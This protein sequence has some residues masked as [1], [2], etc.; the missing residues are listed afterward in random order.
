MRQHTGR[1]PASFLGV[2]GLRRVPGGSGADFQPTPTANHTPASRLVWLFVQVACLRDSVF[3]L[4]TRTTMQAKHTCT[5]AHT[6]TW[7]HTHTPLF[8]VT[9]FSS[10]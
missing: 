4:H 5:H 3:P 10:L 1:P 6:N 9:Y 2:A 8:A 7:M